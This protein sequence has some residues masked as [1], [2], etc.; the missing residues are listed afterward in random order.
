M[1]WNEGYDVIISVHDVTNKFLSCGSNYMVDV[2][3]WQKFDNSCIIMRAV[4]TNSNLNKDL[5]RKMSFFDGYC[6]F[7]LVQ[8]SPPILNMVNSKYFNDYHNFHQ[9]FISIPPENVRKP[10]VF[11]DIRWVCLIQLIFKYKF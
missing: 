3:M 11:L 4:I 8:L 10:L 9:C 5:T 6:W 7:K 1:F 2:V